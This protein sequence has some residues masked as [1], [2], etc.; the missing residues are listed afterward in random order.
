VEKGR[1]VVWSQFDRSVST[2]V[3]GGRD[4]AEG[5][6][7]VETTRLAAPATKLPPEYVLGRILFHA[8]GD[9]RISHDGR[10]CASCHPDGRDDAITWAT[11]EGPR[12]S[13]MLAGRV[14]QS[15]PYAWNGNATTLPGHLGNTF[16]RLS[17]SGLRSLELDALVSYVS[18][19]PAPTSSPV[20]AAEAKKAE[21]GREIFASSE[22]GCANCH[23]GAAYTDGLN[24][25]VGSRDKADR[26]SAF[27]TPSLHL[28]GGTGPYFHDGRYATLSELLVKSDGKMGKTKHLSQA[29]LEV[30]ESFLRTL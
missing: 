2:F 27:N 26:G 9:R 6:P 30:L 12:R 10:A 23:S 7:V 29:D 22:A 4:L 11:P 17:G 16:D 13:I 20:N 14:T 1:A 24:H 3:I 18:S 8:A 28:V 21:R 19:M 25:D 5:A 15:S